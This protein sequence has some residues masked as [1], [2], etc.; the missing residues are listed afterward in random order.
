LFFHIQ[1]WTVGL[2]EIPGT[3]QL[4]QTLPA[5]PVSTDKFRLLKGGKYI[6]S[7]EVPGLKVSGKQLEFDNVTGTN[8]TGVQ[9]KKASPSLGEGTLTL[10]YTAAKKSEKILS[11]YK[12]TGNAS[13]LS[14]KS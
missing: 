8:I 7:Q 9:I 12:A 1:K 13:L 11:R 5:M 14:T 2:D 4:K 6:S 10:N 3:L